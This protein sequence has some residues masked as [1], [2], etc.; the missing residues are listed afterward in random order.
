[1]RDSDLSETFSPKSLKQECFLTFE[2]VN[3]WRP[4]DNLW[5]TRIMRHM[6]EEDPVFGL[7]DRDAHASAMSY[8]IGRVIEK[9]THI[10]LH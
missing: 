8:V 4:T 1:M 9:H 7:E 3:R 10:I 6:A 5:E 2:A